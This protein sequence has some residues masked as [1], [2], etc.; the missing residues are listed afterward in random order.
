VLCDTHDTYEVRDRPGCL[1]VDQHKAISQ[2][3]GHQRGCD[4][5]GDHPQAGSCFHQAAGVPM[6]P[7]EGIERAPGEDGH[8]HRRSDPKTED[9]DPGPEEQGVRSGRQLYPVTQPHRQ[10]EPGSDDLKLDL[11][12]GQQLFSGHVLRAGVRLVHR[13]LLAQVFAQPGER[14]HRPG[15]SRHADPSQAGP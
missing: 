1:S 5:G 14:P 11:P 15:G 10:S 13:A 8:H 9:A 6:H 7:G 3:A 2:R 12:V 4:S